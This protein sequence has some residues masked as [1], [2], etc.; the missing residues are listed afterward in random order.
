MSPA[1]P[2]RRSRPISV[3]ALPSPVTPSMSAT[4]CC[5]PFCG[6]LPPTSNETAPGT[7]LILMTAPVVLDFDGSVGPLPDA[8]VLPLG[9]SQER[10]RFGCGIAAHPAIAPGLDPPLPP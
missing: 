8:V 6:G 7:R 3:P 4:V 5:A 2:T 1:G 10:I 9:A